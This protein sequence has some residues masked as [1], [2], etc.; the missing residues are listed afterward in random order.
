MNYGGLKINNFVGT[1][2]FMRFK[3]LWSLNFNVN[4]NREQYLDRITRGGPV[5]KR[6]NGLS[7]NMNLNTNDNKKVSFHLGTYQR[8]DVS[9]EFDNS[10][11]AGVTILPTTF[12]QLT[13]SPQYNIQKDTDQYVRTVVDELA[14]HTYGSRY[15]FADIAQQSLSA[16]I[17]LNWT[18]SP[19]MSLQT[20]LRPFIASGDYKNFKEFARP[21]TF[22]FDSYGK[23]KGTIDRD[24]N[25]YE[26]DP[27]GNG[28][29]DPFTF[30]NPDF[31]FRSVQ[32]NAVF[33][34]EYTPGSTLFLV[35]QQQ[36][37]DFVNQGSFNLGNDFQE[38]FTA[39]PTNVFLLK[40]SY[41]F[42]S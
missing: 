35:W 7:V 15:V 3:N 40:I 25:T 4:W 22:R 16:S 41:W 31:N 23:D 39:K 30:S 17:R 38:L 21:K 27:D 12:I 32:G 37:S 42:G 14:S 2:G 34:W 13:I 11:W 9:G 29:A 10:I 33:R 18:F 8:Q 19:T 24:G 28:S 1:G 26:V 5:M 36:R 20:Y 6:P